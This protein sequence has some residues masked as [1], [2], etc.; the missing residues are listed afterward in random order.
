MQFS[1]GTASIRTYPRPT[2]PKSHPR[3][4]LR[5]LG[6]TKGLGYQAY[7]L[8]LICWALSGLLQ[9]QLGLNTDQPYGLVN[10][11]SHIAVGARRGRRV[12]ATRG[13][14]KAVDARNGCKTMKNIQMNQNLTLPR[15]NEAP[16]AAEKENPEA[17]LVTPTKQETVANGQGEGTVR[18]TTTQ[19]SCWR[20]QSGERKPDGGESNQKQM[21]SDE[22]LGL[23]SR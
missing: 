6:Y 14:P 5:D 17:S 1:P 20:R 9:W 15:R 4:Y 19:E 8:G 16:N 23:N 13:H 18:S 10:Q 11:Y 12:V 3:G 2:G 21:G 7:G 22:G